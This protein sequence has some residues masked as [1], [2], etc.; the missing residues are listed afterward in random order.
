MTN[1]KTAQSK[2]WNIENQKKKKKQ[3]NQTTF[4]LSTNVTFLD[5]QTKF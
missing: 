5:S 2:G 4:L 3:Y 1:T